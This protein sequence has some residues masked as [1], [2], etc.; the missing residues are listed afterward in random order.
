VVV[1]T[2]RGGL[3]MNV[4]VAHIYGVAPNSPRFRPDLPTSERDDW[5]HLLLLCLPHHG[6]I[7]DKSV[8]ERD[9]PAAELLR[10][11]REKE[12]LLSVPAAGMPTSEQIEE[13]LARHFEE[14]SK[15]LAS[16]VDRLEKVANEAER[17]GQLGASAINEMRLAISLLANTESYQILNTAGAVHEAA[18]ILKSV[19]LE[20]SA[21]SLRDLSGILEDS[22]VRV[23]ANFQELFG[24]E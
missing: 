18:R 20:T 10:W 12:A 13:L 24:V 11:K 14:P 2:G 22:I 21:R 15:R 3:R 6:A 16:L 19:D 9:F 5:R 4:Q 23:R 1:N 7:D 8:G 17:T